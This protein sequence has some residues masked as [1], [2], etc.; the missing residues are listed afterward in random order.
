MRNRSDQKIREIISNR[1]E[2][3]SKVLRYWN[4]QVQRAITGEIVKIK[5]RM[6]SQR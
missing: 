3:L 5:L 6:Q 1:L 4:C 2:P